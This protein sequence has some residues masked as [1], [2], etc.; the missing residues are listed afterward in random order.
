MPIFMVFTGCIPLFRIKEE[1]SG[2]AIL[3]S[4]GHLAKDGEE[5]QE[6]F[7]TQFVYVKEIEAVGDKVD[8]CIWTEDC[9]K[10]P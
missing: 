10:L 9:K 4:G 2:K 1:F 8:G 6:G 5:A 7:P 3:Y